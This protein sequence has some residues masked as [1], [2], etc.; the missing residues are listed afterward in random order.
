MI[1]PT[2]PRVRAL[3]EGVDTGTATGRA[4]VTIVATLVFG[5]QKVSV[6]LDE[7]SAGSP[8]RCSGDGSVPGTVFG[9][10]PDR[11]PS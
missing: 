7:Y 9:Q 2:N 3:G 4:V 8:P 1:S 11:N 6:L 5:R 10:Q